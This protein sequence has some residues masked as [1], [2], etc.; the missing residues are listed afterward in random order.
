VALFCLPATNV[1]SPTFELR[2]EGTMAFVAWIATIRP[3]S[4][5]CCLF[6]SMKPTTFDPI[7][8]PSS[9]DILRSRP[10]LTLFRDSSYLDSNMKNRR[11][12][13]TEFI[14]NGRERERVLRVKGEKL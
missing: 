7:V 2:R 6:M 3:L 5:H 12:I 4:N 9:L 1:E 13:K 10:I 14:G 8:P 11:N